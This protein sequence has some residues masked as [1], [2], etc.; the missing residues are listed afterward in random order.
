MKDLNRKRR[1]KILFLI[2]GLLLL[3]FP[4]L[5]NETMD[6]I[7][8]K[9]IN[10][11]DLEES[12]QTIEQI[13]SDS[14]NPYLDEFSIKDVMLDAIKGK[15]K[16]TPVKVINGITN[17]VFGEV[18][19][20]FK[21][22]GKLMILAIFCTVLSTLS[23]SFNNKSTSQI[24]FYV[25]YIVLIIT[26]T[27]SFLISMQIAQATIDQMTM[28][29]HA[30]VPVM[31]TLL[32]ST[33]NMTSSGVFHPLIV[34]SIQIASIIL[35]NTVL[36]LVFFVSVLEIVS[37]MSDDF[38]ITKLVDLAYSAIKWILKGIVALFIGIMTMYGLTAPIVDGAINKTAKS[39]MTTFV[40]VVGEALSGTVD[41]VMNC[42]VIV[43][44]SYTIGVIIL[45]L[46]ICAIPLIKVFLCMLVYQL[47]SA[48]IEPLS[49]KRIAQCMSGMGRATGYLLG[50]LSTVMVLF[51]LNMLILIGSSNVTTMMR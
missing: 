22:M 51:I 14:T 48:I 37:H 13:K 17:L 33:G 27:E 45:L 1:C 25:C 36:P 42:G 35:R 8:N 38:K 12:E 20:Y 49:D 46:L 4:V 24:A 32:I 39:M 34:S 18:S 50:T 3:S 31:M 44:N 28:I 6:S 9:Q 15:G 16:I 47:T 30:S 19:T 43:K 41:L 21:L 2:I 11:L 5:G 26:L 23:L 7:I 10:I 29:M 40:P